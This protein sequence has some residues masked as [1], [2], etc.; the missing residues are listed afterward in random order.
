MR[1]R[2]RDEIMVSS[3]AYS[4]LRYKSILPLGLPLKG[5]PT[6]FPELGVP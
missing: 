1:V 4:Y 2:I 6:D 5:G 3:E